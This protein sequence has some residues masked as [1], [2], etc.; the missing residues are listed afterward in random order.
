MLFKGH[1][2]KLVLSDH[3]QQAFFFLDIFWTFQTGGCLLLY[4]SS[5]ESSCMSFLH[6]F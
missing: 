2:V 5:A 1:A 3:I 4:E 6:Y